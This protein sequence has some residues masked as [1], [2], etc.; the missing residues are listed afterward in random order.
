MINTLERLFVVVATVSM[1]FVYGM[2]S[3][4]WAGCT[5]EKQP[6]CYAEQQRMAIPPVFPNHEGTEIYTLQSDGNEFATKQECEREG[7]R[8]GLRSFSCVPGR[9]P[10][11]QH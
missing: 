7:V 9:G 2:L 4:A 1:I 11:P 3:M 6:D 8:R 5:K 10:G